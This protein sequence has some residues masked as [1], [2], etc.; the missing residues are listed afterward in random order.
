MTDHEPQGAELPPPTREEAIKAMARAILKAKFYDCAPEAYESL[1]D[2]YA[3]LDAQ[4]QYESLD[5]A[6]D[7]YDALL[8]M[9]AIREGK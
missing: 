1:E 4:H 3:G 8:A 9:G 6:R 2:F 7:A 5:E